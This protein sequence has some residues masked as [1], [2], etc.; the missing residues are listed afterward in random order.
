MRVAWVLVTTAAICAAQQ[1]DEIRVNAHY[2]VPPQAHITAQTSLVQ[3]EVVV[4][5]P[6]GRP[7]S[8]LTSADFQV[9]D[10]GKSRTVSAF[11]VETRTA[12]PAPAKAPKLAV[13][14][15]PPR[16]IL[17][18]FDDLHTSPAEMAHMQT[19]ALRLLKRGL[20][21]GSR[22]AIYTSSQG[23]T[24]EFT[25]DAVALTAAIQKLHAHPHI[26]EGG[27]Q[28][29]PRITPY[30]AYQIERNDLQALTAAVREFEA[31]LSVSDD[32]TNPGG[33]AKANLYTPVS[34]SPNPVNDPHAMSKMSVQ[35][36]ASATMQQV[37]ADS[38]AS[39][40]AISNCVTLLARAP[41]ERILVMVSSGFISGM[42]DRD[43][44]ALVDRA[45]RSAIT[46][47]ALDA[48]GLWS[49][50]PS[51][52]FQQGAETF[53]ALPSD[54]YMF[55]ETSVGSRESEMNAVMQAL[56]SGTGGLF[57]HNSNDLAGGLA[58]LVEVPETAYLIAFRS[59]A[60]EKPGQFH[61]L[62]VRLAGKN[63]ESV[64]TRPGY[65]TVA[66]AASLTPMEPR[67]IDHEI[68]VSEALTQIP[69]QL[70]GR[71]GKGVPNDP[72]L[73]L[74]MH[75]DVSHL[76]F[77]E[78]DGRHMQKL[79]FV[80]ELVDAKGNMIAAKEGAMEFSLQDETLAR[81][82]TNGVNATLALNAPPGAYMVRV[83]VADAEGK[84]AAQNQTVMLGR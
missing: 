66:N 33:T 16:S 31:C 61:K 56:A 49:Q 53:G 64:Q 43:R 48:K 17:L 54:T 55:E 82:K 42:L 11:S 10:D 67:P 80:G 81:L 22:A 19:A 35:S 18:F 77:A 39:L 45:L 27:L 30:T 76:K 29:C 62:K 63:G 70:A 65:V 5:D 23:L 40:D 3:M 74:V 7:V 12:E 34:S 44:D 60:G 20:G 75:V 32:I 4:R 6:H 37:R 2:Y 13:D 72:S 84:M 21:P 79:T 46:I 59:E 15:G 9:L 26:S 36:Q 71:L 8:G 69:L 38:L 41:G 24:L 28:P 68:L 78:K 57:F 73:S 83:V 51:R 47:N 58:E 52:P 1:V 50:A 25:G 14:F